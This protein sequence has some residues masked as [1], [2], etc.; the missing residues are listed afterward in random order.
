MSKGLRDLNLK[1]ILF[2]IVLPTIVCLVIIW[3][4]LNERTL[5]SINPAFQG[6]FVF[7]VQEVVMIV[8]VPMLLGLLWNKWAGGASGFLLGSI[9]A[10]WYGLYGSMSPSWI[11]NMS[12]L[13]YL[14]SAM[15]IGYMA[16]A[17]N[18]KSAKFSRLLFSGFVSG[19]AGGLFLFFTEQQATPLLVYG[20]YGFFVT[21]TPRLVFGIVIPVVA[22][23][24]LRYQAKMTMPQHPEAMVHA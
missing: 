19:L 12:L 16:G 4:P 18:Q 8:A 21:M 7:G 23:L 15:L 20:E 10:L 2:G 24:I 9:Y 22:K 14:L 11:H 13:G 5:A 6:I 17:L 1:D 3:F